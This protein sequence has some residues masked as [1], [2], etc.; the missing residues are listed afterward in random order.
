MARH[1]WYRRQGPEFHS[2]SIVSL[3]RSVVTNYFHSANRKRKCLWNHCSFGWIT[4]CRQL[5][6]GSYRVRSRCHPTTQITAVHSEPL[7]GA[8]TSFDNMLPS[9]LHGSLPGG[10]S[11]TWNQKRHAVSRQ[12]LTIIHSSTIIVH[13]ISIFRSVFKR[14]F[15]FETYG[16]YKILK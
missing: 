13:G 4:D 3:W 14:T 15:S 7:N 1:R 12:L 9:W 6:Q 2:F 5:R 8:G 11:S 16:K 10:D